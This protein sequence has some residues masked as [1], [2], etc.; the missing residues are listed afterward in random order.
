[1]EPLAVDGLGEIA[2]RTERNP[3]AVLIEDRD[4]DDR[5]LGE[6]GILPQRG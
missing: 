3:A 1:M 5:N 6:L 2:R 4:H